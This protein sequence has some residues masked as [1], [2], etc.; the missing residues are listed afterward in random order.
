MHKLRR[1]L[2]SNFTKFP[3]AMSKR[4]VLSF[5]SKTCAISVNGRAWQHNA[6]GDAGIINSSPEEIADCC[7][8]T[9]RC[10]RVQERVDGR[11]NG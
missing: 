5:I 4:L 6:V 8:E 1:E 11:I 9:G 10:E 2:Y 3:G 7:P